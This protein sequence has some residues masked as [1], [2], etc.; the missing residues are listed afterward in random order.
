L[1]SKEAKKALLK[2]SEVDRSNAKQAASI[3]ANAISYEFILKGMRD[4]RSYLIRS[5]ARNK[6]GWGEYSSPAEI[7][8]EKMEIDSKILKAG[9]KEILL[10]WLPKK[11]QSRKLKL[12]FRASKKGFSS[13]AFHSKC[14]N[15]AP[16]LVVVKAKSGNV[17]GGFT[18]VGWGMSNTYRFDKYSFIFLLRRKDK[19]K[20]K[21]KPV[22]K[23]KK[24]DEPPA[25]WKVTNTSN[26]VYHGS[27][28]GPT[29]GGGF[30]FYLCNNCDST[31]GS[32][33]NAGNSYAAPKD[34]NLLAGSYNFMVADY[35]VYELKK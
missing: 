21:N 7:L 29:F 19:K 8:T 27:G 13:A 20:K 9:E 10:G 16:T 17:F 28:Y 5:R 30:D 6:S 25:K 11:Y 12:I 18:T 24:G 33:S 1:S 3:P 15:K 4:S 23:R 35:E 22:K 32:Y 2:P 14:D 34:Q 26:A 31:S